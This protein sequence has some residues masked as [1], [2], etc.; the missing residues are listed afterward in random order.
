M[1]CYLKPNAKQIEFWF[2][3]GRITDKAASGLQFYIQAFNPDQPAEIWSESSFDRL[4]IELDDW[5]QHYKH[6]KLSGLWTAP[7]SLNA[8]LAHEQLVDSGIGV[9]KQGSM[10]K[11]VLSR[12]QEYHAVTVDWPRLIWRLTQ[13]DKNSFRY[14]FLHPDLG[15]WCGATPEVLISVQDRD[16]S[17]MA[18]AG[19]RWQQNNHFPEWTQKEYEEHQWVV[20]EILKALE[21][22]ASVRHGAFYDHQAGAMQHLRTDIIGSLN[23]SST[24][25]DLAR[26]L[27]PTPAVCGYPKN[28]AF[29][30]IHNY[31]GYNRLLYTGYLGL[32]DPEKNSADFYVNLRCLRYSSKRFY[33]YVGGG[34]TADSNP[35][36][37]WQE[38]QRKMTT[39]G[40]VIAPFL[41]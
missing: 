39:M 37:E 33:L 29:D 11:V 25:V 20:Q 35:E 26:S 31:E 34:I 30:F 21:P 22:V 32:I 3:N 36:I 10:R 15:L 13:A 12:A 1:L 40:Q 19:T 16:F 9:I 7:E 38:T 28:T 27:H 5:E 4:L 17:T 8:R 41:E 14:L 6:T 18:L 23:D 2:S 24:V